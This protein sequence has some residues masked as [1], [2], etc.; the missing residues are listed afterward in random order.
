M[1]GALGLFATTLTLT[2]GLLSLLF[3]SLAYVRGR[4][5]SAIGLVAPFGMLTLLGTGF[6]IWLGGF[7]PA[8]GGS[9]ESV[10]LAQ[11]AAAA[12]AVPPLTMGLLL[13]RRITR[14]SLGEWGWVALIAVSL[15]LS[16]VGLDQ[17]V[18][19]AARHYN[20]P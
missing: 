3:G 11:V 16:L 5:G 10:Q 6:G 19:E 13:I 20:C 14:K 15:V 8:I 18:F 4:N 12:S 1:S 7:L 9:R 17:A 2:M